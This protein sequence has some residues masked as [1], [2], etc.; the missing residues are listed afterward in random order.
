MGMRIN[1]YDITT[2]QVDRTE[3]HVVFNGVA[4]LESTKGIADIVFEGRHEKGMTGFLEF[5]FK[6]PDEI[7][8]VEIR[9]KS[10]EIRDILAEHLLEKGYESGEYREMIPIQE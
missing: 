10:E 2:Y 4:H 9:E 8:V 6:D 3:K 7:D 1:G 5:F